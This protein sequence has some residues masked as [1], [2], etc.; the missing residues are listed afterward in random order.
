MKSKKPEKEKRISPIRKLF[1]IGFSMLIAAGLIGLI[2]AVFDYTLINPGKR[3]AT[4]SI[5]FTYEGAA[6]GLTPTG[7]IL[8]LDGVKNKDL[9]QDVLTELGLDG[10]YSIEAIQDS[11]DV[12]ASYPDDV[13]ARVQTYNSLYDFSASRDVQQENFYPTIVGITLYDDFDTSISEADM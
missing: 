11:L 8:A 12:K 9:I 13:L 1:R 2:Y 7:E 10:K 3:S 4:V 6:N 5:E